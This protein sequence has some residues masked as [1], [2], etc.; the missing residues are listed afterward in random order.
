MRS[1]ATARVFV[2][3]PIEGGLGVEVRDRLSLGATLATVSVATVLE[4]AVTDNPMHPERIHQMRDD[5]PPRSSG[6]AM[7][8]QELGALRI[9]LRG[10]PPRVEICVAVREP[11]VRRLPRVPGDERIEPP[12][13]QRAVGNSRSNASETPKTT[14]HNRLGKASDQQDARCEIKRRFD[15][16]TGSRARRTR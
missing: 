7:K 15:V 9:R 10:R 3:I 11:P 2:T 13:P 4:A 8:Q 12:Q 16:I 1:G 5:D 14:T 6:V